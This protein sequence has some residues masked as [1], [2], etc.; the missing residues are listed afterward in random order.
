MTVSFVSIVKNHVTTNM[1]SYI[2]R[3]KIL[4]FFPLENAADTAL[5]KLMTLAEIVTSQNETGVP[6][7][8]NK[9]QNRPSHRGLMMKI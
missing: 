7:V 4:A 8:P 1:T 5:T 3:R 6:P 9:G 2:F